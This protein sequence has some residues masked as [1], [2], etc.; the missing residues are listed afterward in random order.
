[1][2][3]IRT[4]PPL[5]KRKADSHKGT[6]GR[7]LIL[8]GSVGMTG[9]ACLAARAALRG[10]AGLVTLG[11]PKSLNAIADP[12]TAITPDTCRICSAITTLA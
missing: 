2:K 12:T 6:Y 3:R 9:A 5:P 7:V 1:M 4:L 8:A 11:I 10:G